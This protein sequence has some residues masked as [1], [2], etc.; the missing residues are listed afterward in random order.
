M[1]RFFE[2]FGFVFGI[3]FLIGFCAYLN[4]NFSRWVIELNVKQECL[5]DKRN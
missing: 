4:F 3:I 2:D 5:N 1:I